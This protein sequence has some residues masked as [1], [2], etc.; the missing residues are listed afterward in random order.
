[1]GL[2]DI[3][4]SPEAQMAAGLL[5]GGDFGT[6]LARGQA[7]VANAQEHAV[8]QRLMQA[9]M[10]NFESEVAQRAAALENQKKLQALYGRILGGAQ[11]AAP[12]QLGSGSFGIVDPGV[13]RGGNPIT[14]FPAPTSAGQR[15]ANASLDD[16]AQIELL[17]G[18]NLLPFY[19]QA[20]EGVKREPG[21]FYEV[22]GKTT[23]TPKIPE[24][25][26]YQDGRISVIPGAAESN[27]SFKGA[28]TAAVEA[29]KAKMNL[30][31]LGYVDK[32]TGR[33][34]GGSVYGYLNGKQQSQPARSM[35]TIRND[36][37]TE[38]T[39]ELQAFLN[40]NADPS[41]G[42][43]TAK[44]RGAKPGQAYGLPSGVAPVEEKAAGGPVEL[45]SDAEAT[46]KK[47]WAE[48]TTIDTAEMR[49]QIMTSAYAAPNVIAK[50]GQI[51]RLL[52]DHDGGK[53]SGM[54]TDIASIANSVGVKMDKNLPN[55]EA[56][57]SLINEM[58]LDMRST[59]NGG[60]MP[61]AMSDKDREFLIQMIPRAEQSADG[62]AEL[63]RTKIAMEKRKQQV[64]S[65]ARNYENK[66][67]PLDNR[68][69]EQLQSWS[70]EH[71]LFKG[72]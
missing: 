64:A 22:G 17:G 46:S 12:G 37:G 39:P 5:G 70:N 25:M 8:K 53:L 38:L 27:A 23:Y 71:P 14:Q 29:E 40:A 20:V 62:R 30:L 42:P 35:G 36:D 11:P 56:A 45:Q 34:V 66:Y 10:A 32:G 26:M 48:K 52:A 3:L 57:A 4:T 15:I 58:A 21:N 50:L 2:L 24:N 47:T 49:K 31:P 18:K 9:Q 55:K 7:A 43:V 63:I 19:K 65:F 33:P 41:A 72:K 51:G 61:G 1:M 28:E 16:L 6:Q 69:F 54:G 67:G 68:F 59:A 13:D 44:F 60:G